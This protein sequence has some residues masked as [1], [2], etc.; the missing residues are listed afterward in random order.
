MTV[1]CWVQADKT[2]SV[3]V[4]IP[5]LKHTLLNFE[6]NNFRKHG[7]LHLAISEIPAQGV[8]TPWSMW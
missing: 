4:L 5:K 2:S 1:G 7:P 6:N 8:V 3:L